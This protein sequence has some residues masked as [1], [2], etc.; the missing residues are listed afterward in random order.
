LNARSGIDIAEATLAYKN[1]FI[2][3]QATLA[4]RAGE[5][6]GILGP[7]GA[8]KSS[9]FNILCGLKP[10]AV[11]RTRGAFTPENC[12]YLSQTITPPPAL[13]MYEIASMATLLSGEQET[14]ASR[15]RPDELV[16]GHKA[17]RFAELGRKRSGVCSYGEKRWF[18]AM[19][20][21][22]VERD[23]YILDEPTSG[24]DPEYRVYLWQAIRS[25]AKRGK[26]VLVSSHLV[27]EI[28]DN[29]NYFYFL[30]DGTFTRYPDGPA[31]M[32]AFGCDSLDE[33]FIRA[34]QGREN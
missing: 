3:N 31:F 7:N 33:A 29:C 16:G 22:S 1:R 6:A 5:V 12:V 11:L 4:V 21:L 18:I 19:C 30:V 23:V 20:L 34:A 24:V 10:T 17:A 15:A 28:V 14:A 9:F 27:S 26:T 25:P 8:G 2:L 13:K 32:E